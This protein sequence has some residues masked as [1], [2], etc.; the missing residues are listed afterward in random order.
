MCGISAVA[1]A[2]ASLQVVQ[3][4]VASLAHRGPD[5]KGVWLSPCGS[6]ALGHC[7]LS[8]LDLSDRAN[9]P[10]STEDGNLTLVYNGEIFNYRE[11]REQ[12]QR[13]GHRFRSTS[14]TE[15]LIRLYQ[16][17]GPDMLERLNGMFAF[18]LFDVRTGTLFAA[19][20]R[21]GVKPLY[22]APLPGGGLAIASELKSL[23]GLPGVDRTLDLKAVADLLAYQFIPDPRTP[24][25]G[26]RRL[27]MGHSLT[28]Q[29]GQVSIQRWQ[30]CE[31]AERGE[32][33]DVTLRE[34]A[35]MVRQALARG[36]ERQLVSDRPVGAFLS[37]G[38]DS[39]AVVAAMARA[40]P[41]EG[42]R[43]YTVKYP[44]EERVLDPFDEDLPH[45]QAVAAALGVSLSVLEVG[46]D[47]A[48]LW[49]SLVWTLDEPVADPAAVN[50]YLIAQRAR[51]DGTPVLLTGQGADELFGGYR[52][53]V[54]GRL[55]H[56]LD[57]L[58]PAGRR[59]L[60]SCA[61]GLPAGHGG[62]F[63]P[64]LRRARKL[65]EVATVDGDQRFIRLCA[66]APAHILQS[67][68]SPAVR[69]ELKQYDP[70]DEGVQ[71][72]SEVGGAH[73]VDR[74]LYRDLRTYL[75]AQN[76]HYTDR[77]TMAAGVEARVPFL[78]N[79]LADLAMALPPDFKLRGLTETKVVLREAVRPWLPARILHRSKAGF[80]VPL[81]GWLRGGLAAM[82]DDLLAPDVVARRGIL[83]PAEVARQRR[84]FQRG[85][86]DYAYAIFT[87]LTLELWCRAFL[88]R[89]PLQTL[90]SDRCGVLAGAPV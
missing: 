30:D 4:M 42:I 82:A 38:L 90:K 84:A 55:L 47:V 14:D 57:L 5:G 70:L 13:R 24:V 66:T 16:E 8:I 77:A 31:P 6:V 17:F 22:Y 63:G 29:H 87:Y 25:V 76:L 3:E 88:D 21:F 75:P 85:E 15:V 78:D 49:P 1:G 11:F 39:S 20:D 56:A 58:P 46:S 74:M 34:A 44:R 54:A 81:R 10:F 50:A 72:L 51:A 86:A 12:L 53:H 35:A 33:T 71:L 27:P 83:A 2:G 68:L 28:W 32:W 80:S 69:A 52:R 43:C 59:V 7:R 26:I 37:G 89:A 61:E 79:D 45:A 64:I 60:A 48:S 62:R 73:P 41:A 40:R 9:Q 67:V 23:M 19:R 36:V 18:A 65:L